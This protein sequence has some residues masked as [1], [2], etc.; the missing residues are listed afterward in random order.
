MPGD[1][2]IFDERTTI[3]ELEVVN[4]DEQDLKLLLADLVR[5][6]G[7]SEH[8]LKKLGQSLWLSLN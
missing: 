4:V 6:G 2:V 5:P 8:L 3:Q 7:K 1:V